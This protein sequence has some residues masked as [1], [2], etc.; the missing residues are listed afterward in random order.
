MQKPFDNPIKLVLVTGFGWYMSTVVA[1]IIKIAIPTP[2]KQFKA[3]I[4]IPT[5][6]I[7]LYT[8]LLKTTIL[9]LS[10]FAPQQVR[11]Q[12]YRDCLMILFDETLKKEFIDSELVFS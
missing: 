1:D 8:L 2:L 6:T 4:S 12:V 3:P 5:W 11:L 10:R 7:I 9:L